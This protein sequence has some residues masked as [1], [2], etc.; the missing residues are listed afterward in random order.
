MNTDDITDRLVERLKG[1]DL[2]TIFDENGLNN[3]CASAIKKAFFEERVD[4]RGYGSSRLPPLLVEMAEQT[5]KELIA[6]ALEPVVKSMIDDPAF[7]EM[8]HRAIM[9]QI[10]KTADM[11]ATQIVMRSVEEAD[12]IITDKI[13]QAVGQKLGFA[14]PIG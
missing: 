13:N 1:G 12:R 8:I 9:R 6:E 5:F 7:N 11:Y 3:L 10:P 14:I 4:P 2:A